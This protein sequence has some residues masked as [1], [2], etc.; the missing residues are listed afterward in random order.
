MWCTVDDQRHRDTKYKVNIAVED[1][2]G[3][4]DT[5]DSLNVELWVAKI[6]AGPAQASRGLQDE[7]GRQ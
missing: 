4:L 1:S 2:Q 7:V 5:I 6:K 3:A